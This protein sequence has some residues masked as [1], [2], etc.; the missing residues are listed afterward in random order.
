M[1]RLLAI[2]GCYRPHSVIEQA[3]DLSLQAAAEAGAVTET[4]RLRDLPVRTCLDCGRCLQ[5]GCDEPAD[6]V[7]RNEMPD[8]LER[9]DAADGFVLAA[10]A[11][12][13]TAHN[14]FTHFIV[15]LMKYAR[16]HRVNG[17]APPGARP[18]LLISTSATPGLIGRLYY[19]TQPHLRATARA[20]GAI[21]AGSVFI[22]MVAECDGKCL[23]EKASERLRTLTGNLL[24]GC[25]GAR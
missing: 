23:P 8:V 13:Y 3:V 4:I 17:S 18:A 22:G 19:T 9:I 1:P 2:N 14:V 20:L 6:C 11:N 25:Q 24:Q 7:I 10:P 21:P 16:L 15:R 5:P 12:V